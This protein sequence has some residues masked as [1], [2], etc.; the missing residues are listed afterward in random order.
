MRVLLVNDYAVTGGYGTEAYV[1]RLAAGLT[2]AG[3]QVEIWAGEVSHTG[4][5]KLLDLWD[6]VA[7]RALAERIAA[8]RPDVVH[9]HNVVRELSASVLTAPGPRTP[10]VLTVHDHRLL[11]TPDR[12]PGAAGWL[13]YAGSA[14]AS[15][16]V[17]STARRR[18]TATTAVSESLADRLRSAG[19]PHVA[20]VP[21]PVEPPATSPQPV[22]QCSDIAVIGRLSPDK[23]PNLALDAFAQIAA[24]HPASR[25]VVV[26]D[27]PF[28]AAL[29]VRAQPLGDRV[30]FTGHLSPAEVSAILGSSRLVVA[31]SVPQQRPEG[32]PTVVPE[33]AVHGRPIVVSDDAGLA[34]V[35]TGLGGA[36][37]TPSRDV[38][39]LAKAIDGLLRDPGRAAELGDTAR[40]NVEARHGLAAVT[41]Q[42][43]AVYAAAL[44]RTRATAP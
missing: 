27:G 21:V 35:A 42:M 33:A 2:A 38:T 5:R 1:R 29:R 37:V 25:L 9:F 13:G 39:A 18:V 11:G 36:V 23:G 43:R 15:T 10:A 32:A 40:R 41:R 30:R 34:A 16:L 14:A 3:D 44:Q 20:V 7:R 12:G 24:D 4:A 19:W 6:P 26:G 22:A 28:A 17:R 8:F 31:A